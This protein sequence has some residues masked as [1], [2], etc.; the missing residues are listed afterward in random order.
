MEMEASH[1][2]EVYNAGLDKFQKQLDELRANSTT[3]AQT[4]DSLS[5]EFAEFRN[6]IHDMLGSLLRKSSDLEHRVDEL[7]AKGRRN[8][9]LLHGV[10]EDA[11][12][13]PFTAALSVINGKLG[14]SSICS[15]NLEAC[16]RL[17]PANTQRPKPRPIV[18]R[19][20]LR[21]DRQA[22]W[23]KKKLLK[24]SPV[25]ITESLIRSRQLIFMEAR[26]V[27]KPSNCWTRDGKVV[28]MFPDGCKEIITRPEQLD[29]AKLRLSSYTES[30]KVERRNIPR[31]RSRK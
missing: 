1:I 11:A 25:L 4:L 27:F 9:L 13:S 18:V 16:Y 12:L 21:E 15:A 7:E 3:P 24:S 29:Q 19:F 6:K 2:A 8:T 28:V 22:V 20:V 23:S 10:K 17:G 30:D 26:T 14:C 31:T 5:S